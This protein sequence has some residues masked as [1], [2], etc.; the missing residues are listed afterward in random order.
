MTPALVKHTYQFVV[1]AI[2]QACDDLIA[3]ETAL[4]CAPECSAC[5]T[6]RVLLTTLEGAYLA[7]GLIKS[8]REDL[9][10]QAT[11]I[12]GANGPQ[13][14][15]T[16]NAWARSCLEGKE[17]APEPGQ[18][19]G[20][21]VCPLL[22]DGLCSAYDYR[23]LACRT[24]MSLETCRPGGAALQRPWWVTISTALFQV[25]EQASL[26]GWFG[27]M[28]RVLAK[29]TDPEGASTQRL[30]PCKLLPGLPAP[31]QHQKRLQ[32]AMDQLFKHQV[33]GRPLGQWLQD[34][35]LQN[36]GSG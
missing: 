4:A 31:A 1:E 2:F 25:V 11:R 36:Q 14:S 12:T 22:E 35:R 6:G 19:Q 30:L 3:A 5:C 26:G 34:I 28:C 29:V 15:A 21:G 23:P 20:Q 13:V 10:K 8:G 32:K 33:R 9:I 17:P 24:M 7:Q 16:F 18:D 27:P